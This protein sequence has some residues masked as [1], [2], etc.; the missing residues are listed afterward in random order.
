MPKIVDHAERRREIAG[1]LLDIVA[2]RGANAVTFRAV[3]DR[4]GWSTGVLGHYFRNREDLLL[5][6][7]R[8]AGELSAERQRAIGASMIGRQ[9]VE[10]ILEEE[11]PL[12]N[13]R[14][15]LTRIFIFFYAEA[16]VDPTIMAEIEGYLTAWRR[17][18][19]VAIE[20]AQANGDIDPSLDAA[21]TAADLVALADGLSIHVIFNPALMERLRQSSPIRTWVSRL[22]AGS[23]AS[24]ST[25]AA[26]MTGALPG[27]DV[28][29]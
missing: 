12:D 26:T 16:A 8:R 29:S 7:L 21:Q 4:S 11:L 2:E 6:G 20:A 23:A 3:A 17:Q 25:S 14:L 9:A 10:A 1:A 19:A 27:K 18:T 22:S 24:P 15:A 13:R 5:G 28:V